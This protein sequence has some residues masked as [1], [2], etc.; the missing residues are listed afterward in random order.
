[1]HFDL[2]LD[3]EFVRLMLH[4]CV[5]KL[6]QRAY[7]SSFTDMMCEVRF[8]S[9]VSDSLVQEQ[10]VLSSIYFMTGQLSFSVYLNTINC[11][12]NSKCSW[13]T[14]YSEYRWY[15]EPLESPVDK[16]MLYSCMCLGAYYL[17]FNIKHHIQSTSIVLHG[18]T[19]DI[20]LWLL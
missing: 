6:L 13:Q 10:M 5:I 17:C 15:Q 14:S 9:T 1:M 16:V 12:F 2:I 20:N 11:C 3:D 8:L 4:L 18:T 7:F 19:N